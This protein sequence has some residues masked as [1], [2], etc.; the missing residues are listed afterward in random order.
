VCSGRRFRIL[1]SERMQ[2]DTEPSHLI[3]A[4]EI[5]AAVRQFSRLLGSSRE[6]SSAMLTR[7]KG[8]RVRSQDVQATMACNRR[9]S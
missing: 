6:S 3:S 7:T 2:G 1:H 9:S 4:N 8:R 5:G